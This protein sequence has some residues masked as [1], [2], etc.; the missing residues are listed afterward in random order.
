[1]KTN[2]C[3]QEQTVVAA[4]RTGTFPDD[5]LAHAGACTACTEVML[6]TQELLQEVAAVPAELQTPNPALVWRR[7]EAFARKKSIAEATQP[8]RIVRIC[9]YVVGILSLPWLVRTCLSS[10]SWISGF[11][12]HLWTMDLRSMD[13]PLSNTLPATMLVGLIGS[14]IF[15]GLSSWYVIR[16]E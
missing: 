2:S 11:V 15:I 6:V 16:Q 3:D 5:L 13:R 7:A 8:I 9:A 14:L 4:V 12:R 10:P 1:M